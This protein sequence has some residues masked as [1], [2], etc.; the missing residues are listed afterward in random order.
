MNSNEL[1][2]QTKRALTLVDGLYQEIALL[3]REVEAALLPHG[4]I[5]GRPSGYGVTTRSSSGLESANVARW[6]SRSF[7]TFFVKESQTVVASGTTRTEPTQDLRLPFLQIE[8]E[9]SPRVIV[10][11]L[12]DIVIHHKSQSKFE[13][14]VGRLIQFSHRVFASPPSIDYS[15][16]T[17]SFKGHFEVVPLFELTDV[18][19][20][21][22]RRVRVLVG[23][24]GA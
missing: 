4:Y 6:L 8:L 16:S 7:T 22:E 21:R 14:H 18:Q 23:A 13:N 17:L 19:A 9:P 2:Q 5:I 12:T 10:G 20:I 15:D 11:T 3:I 24:S 1:H